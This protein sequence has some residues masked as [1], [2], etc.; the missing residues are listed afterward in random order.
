MTKNDEILLYNREAWDKQVRSGNVWTVPVSPDEVNRARKGDWKVVLT[1]NKPVPNDWFGDLRGKKLLGLASGGGQQGPLFSA[2]GAQVTIFDNSPAQLAQDRMVSDR[3][4]LSIETVQGDMQDLSRFPNET[5]DLIFH[6]CS[7]CFVPDIL[8]VWKEAFR[9][10]KRGGVLLSGIVNPVVF[11]MDL[12]LER[13]GIA[14]MKYKI[15]Y[16]DLEHQ[17]DPEI[18][19]FRD[20]GEPLSFGHT[21][22]DQLGGQ[23]RAGFHIIGIYEDTWK[24]AKEPVHRFIP[25]YLATRA[26]KP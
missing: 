17:E 15:P 9:V 16:S 13:E 10:L 24:E 1:P 8:P 22:E 20:A 4:G 12:A 23:T 25:A 5:F 6:P 7:N 2:A 19:K 14:Q 3:D 26:L 18:K 21:L 11:T